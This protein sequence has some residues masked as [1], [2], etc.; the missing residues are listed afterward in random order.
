MGDKCM[1]AIALFLLCLL[2]MQIH[3]EAVSQI[4][5]QGQI[6]EK[7]TKIPLKDVTVFILPYK[8]KAQ[9]DSK[10][11]FKFSEIPISDSISE[12]KPEIAEGSASASVVDTVNTNAKISEITW[13]VNL[14]GYEKLEEVEELN[15]KSVQF[16]DSQKKVFVLFTLKNQSILV[17]KQ[18]L[19]ALKIKK[20]LR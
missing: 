10:G 6:L 11:R 18:L 1:A 12:A 8:V 17:L 13:V 2:P 3:A 20:T 9:T 16:N 15:S 4:E 5:L 19:L 7:G 14:P